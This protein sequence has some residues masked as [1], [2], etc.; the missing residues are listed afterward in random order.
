MTEAGEEES[1]G[2]VVVLRWKHYD[3]LVADTE[4][5]DEDLTNDAKPRTT[6]LIMHDKQ[7][8]SAVS[9]YAALS[10]FASTLKNSNKYV[11]CDLRSHTTL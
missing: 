10:K 5:R 7:S 1:R 8:L 11:L 9:H 3:S 4:Q 2:V 6:W